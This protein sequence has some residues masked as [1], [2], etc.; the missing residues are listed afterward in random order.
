MFAEISIYYNNHI[1]KSLLI[2]WTRTCYM[3]WPIL[4][5]VNF[6]YESVKS[7][8]LHPNIE[9]AAFLYIHVPLWGTVRR[10]SSKVGSLSVGP[11]H[12]DKRSVLEH[13]WGQGAA[14]SFLL[15]LAQEEVEEERALN[16]EHL[17]KNHCAS[18]VPENI[19]SLQ[20]LVC[21]FSKWIWISNILSTSKL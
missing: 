6:L 15:C 17:F 16:Q 18:W 1:F 7:R 8:C 5:H 20:D 3:K 19:T 10:S 9:K 21:Y 2:I 4:F 14:L 12:S 13:P 11:S